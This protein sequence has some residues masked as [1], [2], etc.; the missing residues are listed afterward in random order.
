MAE[1]RIHSSRDSKTSKDD[2][3]LLI[4]GMRVQLS[5]LNS[6]QRRY[7]SAVSNARK[8]VIQHDDRRI[9]NGSTAERSVELRLLLVSAAN[10]GWNT[11]TDTV[12]DSVDILLLTGVLSLNP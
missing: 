12:L 7:R 10:N 4:I 11:E 6:Q 3:D 9:W 1:A 2:R 5:I 8:A